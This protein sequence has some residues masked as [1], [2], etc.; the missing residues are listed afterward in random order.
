MPRQNTPRVV[1]ILA[2]ANAQLL[3]ITGPLQVFATANDLTRATLT[4]PPY[5][6]LVIARGGGPVTCSAGLALMTQPLPQLDAPLDTL[7][8]AGGRG[9]EAAAAD[10]ALVT[11]VRARAAAARRTASV[12]SGA[13]LLAETGLFD[14]RRVATHWRHCQ[15]LARR[16][17]SITVEAEPIFVQDGPMWSSA[18]VTAGIDL[19]LALVEEDLGRD[20]ALAVARDLVVYLK[21]PGGQ[22]QYSTMLSLQRSSRFA[23]LHDWMQDNLGGDLS[24][25]RLARQCAMSERSFSRHYAE[26]M[27]TTPARAVERLRIEAARSLLSGTKLPVKSVAKQCGFQNEETLRRSFIRLFSTSPQDYRKNWSVE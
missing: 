7:I 8:I 5:A 3:D 1:E 6:P 2:F 25:N 18:G 14:G 19:C 26:E 20:V 16:F 17:P 21:R 23:G 12:C 15:G 10:S 24:L 27:G 22:S 9:I 4:I 13:F 11:W